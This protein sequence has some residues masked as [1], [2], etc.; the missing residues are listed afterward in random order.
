MRSVRSMAAGAALLPLM[1]FGW[2]SGH[3]TVARAVAARLPPPWGERVQGE[4][5]RRF[6]ADNHWPDSFE[7]FPVE[8]VGEEALA[9]LTARKVTRR[10]D[11]HSDRGRAVAFCLLVRAI[12]EEQPDRALLWL[13]ALAHSTADMVACNHDPVVHVATYGWC[14]PD[15]GMALPGGKG[16]AEVTGCLDLGW[17]EKAS[18]A[19]EAFE[20]QVEEAAL[21]DA[22]QG[23]EALLLE[24]MLYGAGGV[25]T[26]APHGPRVLSAAAE[27]VD[28]GRR[29]AGERL[30]GELSALG[31]WAVARTLRDFAAAVRLAAAGAEPDVTEE[32]AARYEAAMEA[33]VRGRR[34][35]DDLFAREALAPLGVEGPRIG[36][37]AEPCW[38]MNEGM[39]GFGDRVLAVQI[40]NTLRRQGRNAELVDVRRFLA[41][42]AA[43]GTAALV[44]PA[45]RVASY[46]LMRAD[47][48]ERRLGTYLEGGGRVVWV[49]GGMPPAALCRELPKDFMVKGEDKSWPAPMEQFSKG[50]LN[51]GERWGPRFKCEKPP[52]GAAGWHWPSNPNVFTDGAVKTGV[53]LVGWHDGFNRTKPVGL[54]W[55]KDRPKVAYVPGYAVMPFIWTLENPSLYPLRLELD[56]AGTAVLELA[57]D[58]IDAL[59]PSAVW[60]TFARNEPTHVTVNWVTE[61]PEVSAVRFGPDAACGGGRA[62]SGGA[63][64]T[65]HHVEVPLPETGGVWYRI[66]TGG[67]L[68][69]PTRVR[70]WDAEEL[71]VAMVADWG[72]AG[73]DVSAMVRDDIHLLVTGGDHV[74]ALHGG[75]VAGEAAKTN[76]APHLRLLAAY[77]ALFRQVP[78]MPVLGNHD[79]EIRPR[80]KRETLTEPVY[81]VDATAYRMLFPL[82]DKGWCW[83]F[84]LPRFGV[85]FVGLDLNHMQDQGT[86]LQS[87]HDFGEGSE[88]LAWYREVMEGKAPCFTLTLNNEKSSVTRGL[89]K[90]EWGRLMRRGTLTATGFG[91]FAER[92]E[93]EGYPWFN[94]SLNG[95]GDVY[96]DPASAF[97]ASEDSYLLFRFRRGQAEMTAEIRRLA[98]GAVLDAKK[99]EARK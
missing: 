28:T 7:P 62:A 48:L 18:W 14:S 67:G 43:E 92:A 63:A 69:A 79:R 51:V 47:E 91:Y 60:L 90:G 65:L 56:A 39:F 61:R 1:V 45:Q 30:A 6:C 77:P 54:A 81:D 29:E 89:A 26:C 58:T 52:V 5:L 33:F 19:K 88:Q 82:P 93:T 74:A 49:G 3:G 87:C 21:A 36:V 64:G 97:L 71:R 40:V 42:G 86:L 50:W 99:V 75:G 85:R 31:A 98:D 8:R 83:R 16:F 9:Y 96:R 15:W 84:E 11:L 35:E 66:E 24:I 22:G 78:V 25:E 13:A 32:V 70:G 59:K 20:R 80:G 95:R 55:P 37:L 2:G 41:E 23:A 76:L 68:T 10:Y 72:F 12:R 94:T 38:R 46:R 57:L 17:L 27:W 73:A 4:T 53:G 44:V 34:L